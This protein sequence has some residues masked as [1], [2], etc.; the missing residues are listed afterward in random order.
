MNKAEN[1]KV[2]STNSQ[3]KKK[4]KIVFSWCQMGLYVKFYLFFILHSNDH[5]TCGNSDT[6]TLW[7][8][9]PMFCKELQKYTGQRKSLKKE[10]SACK[11]AFSSLLLLWL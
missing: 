4:K 6:K 8:H 7:N 10:S 2:K 9:V 1:E 5:Q 3:K 11:Q